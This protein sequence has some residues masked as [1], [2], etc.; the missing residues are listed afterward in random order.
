[1]DKNV[2]IVKVDKRP[3]RTI[4]RENWGLTREQM[5]GTHVH[6]RIPRS[7]GGT[8]D[9]SNLY[10]CSPWF[11]DVIWHGGSGGFI[12]MAAKGG[13]EGGIKGNKTNRKNK[14]A[15][16]DPVVRERGRISQREQKIGFYD[17][18]FHDS[19]V[20]REMRYQNGLKTGPKAAA[21]GQLDEARKCINPK[22][23]SKS[24]KNNIKKAHEKTRKPV[25]VTTPQGQVIRFASISEAARALSIDASC[26]AGAARNPGKKTKGHTAR[27]T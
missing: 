6:H 4:A 3:Y 8:N 20:M 1:M 9:P 21:S 13:R 19:P 27:F 12:G 10:V 2:S 11:H 7:E 23:R 18:N 26:I 25:E 14:T 15:V 24:S 22:K 16:Y 17:R 5:K